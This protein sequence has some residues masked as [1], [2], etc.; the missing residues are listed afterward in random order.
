MNYFELN[1]Y[2]K[3]CINR[4]CNNDTHFEWEDGNFMG[5]LLGGLPEL[6]AYAPDGKVPLQFSELSKIYRSYNFIETEPRLFYKQIK[7]IVTA[8]SKD[9]PYWFRLNLPLVKDTLQS[10]KSCLISGEG[11]IGKSYFIKCFEQE[12]SKRKTKHLCLYGKFNQI[13]SD[14]DFDEIAHIAEREEFVFAFAYLRRI[15]R[16]IEVQYIQPHAPHE[17]FVPAPPRSVRH[18]HNRYSVCGSTCAESQCRVLIHQQKRGLVCQRQQEPLLVKSAEYI[19]A[20]FGA[21]RKYLRIFLA[22]HYASWFALYDIDRACAD[23]CV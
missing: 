9:H 4:T 18:A 10:H 17:E 20:A 1:E 15:I 11:G 7:N 12:L 5:Y 22:V 19:A 23:I 8:I 13:I 14:I 6:K 3:G 16:E 21:L 2:N